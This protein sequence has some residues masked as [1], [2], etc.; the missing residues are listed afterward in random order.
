[1]AWV[2]QGQFSAA[3]DLTPT[4]YCCLAGM[5]DESTTMLEQEQPGDRRTT[6]DSTS[7]GNGRRWKYFP[8]PFLGLS[9]R[10][11]LTV[12]PFWPITVMPRHLISI[13]HFN[14]FHGATI[15]HS[16]FYQLSIWLAVCVCVPACT[17]VYHWWLN[18][19]KNWQAQPY[20]Q[21]SGIPNYPNTLALSEESRSADFEI[22]GRCFEITSLVVWT[23]CL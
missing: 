4:F 2:R 1:M 7:K 9:C 6:T 18:H 13:G 10:L 15:A 23:L 20:T 19:K 17:R 16:H 14:N 22:S 3:E 12:F 8:D 11:C 5:S 21:K